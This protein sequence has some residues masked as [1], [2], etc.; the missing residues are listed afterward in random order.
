MLINMAHNGKQCTVFQQCSYR[1]L[2]YGLGLPSCIILLLTGSI[3]Q[4]YVGS[5]LH[6]YSFQEVMSLL[7]QVLMQ[8]LDI[9]LPRYSINMTIKEHE[10]CIKQYNMQ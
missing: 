4:L 10:S 1:N 7:L 3:V 8:K 9:K 6:Y 2:K 5:T